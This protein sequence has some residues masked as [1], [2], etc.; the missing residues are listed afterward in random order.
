MLQGRVALNT[1]SNFIQSI[2]DVKTSQS[3]GSI[4]DAIPEHVFVHQV[5][6]GDWNAKCFVYMA[7]LFCV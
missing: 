1:N 3:A 4:D 6:R 2:K 5:Y 7:S